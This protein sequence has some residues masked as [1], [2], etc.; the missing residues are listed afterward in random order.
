M[1]HIGKKLMIVS[2]AVAASGIAWS[3][4]SD[5]IVRGHDLMTPAEHAA[6]HQAMRVLNPQQRHAYRRQFHEQLE[7]RAE[8]AGMA[9]RSIAYTS[10]KPCC[11]RGMGNSGYGKAQLA[12]QRGR[13][14]CGQKAALNYR[15]RPTPVGV[16]AK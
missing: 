4:D 2:L 12:A 7:E 11:G 9:L 1:K 10:G 5:R 3:N 6:H 14:G 13:H 16:V 15:Q 8:A